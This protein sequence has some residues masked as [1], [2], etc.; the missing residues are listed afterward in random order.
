MKFKSKRSKVAR[1]F[2]DVQEFEHA[3]CGSS[4][5]HGDFSPHFNGAGSAVVVRAP[6][7]LDVMGGISDCCGS[8]VCELPLGQAVILALQK[9][10]DRRVRVYSPCVAAEGGAPSAEVLLDDLYERGKLKTCDRVAALFRRDPRTAWVAHVAGAFYALVRENCAR[11]FD[12]GADIV[13]TSTI[14][15]GTGLGAS[16]AVEVAALHALNIKFG[17]KLDGHR[18]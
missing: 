7:R 9:R 3:L 4:P 17:L 13:I 15:S 18:L 12:V 1:D 16:A 14:P 5:V 6:A 11:A 2:P 8:L 10:K